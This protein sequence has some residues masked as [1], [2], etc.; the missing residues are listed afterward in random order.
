MLKPAFQQKG[1]SNVWANNCMAGWFWEYSFRDTLCGEVR[2]SRNNLHKLVCG[3]DGE[4]GKFLSRTFH[5]VWRRDCFPTWQWCKTKYTTYSEVG[6]LGVI[7]GFWHIWEICIGIFKN[8]APDTLEQIP[9]T[10]S[11]KS[12]SAYSIFSQLALD[13]QISWCRCLWRNF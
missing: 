12:I 6:V 2:H 9:W 11:I 7:I 4:S 13:I 8:F 3:V 1:E 10:Y 5:C